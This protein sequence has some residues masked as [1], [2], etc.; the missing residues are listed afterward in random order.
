[1]NR[2]PAKYCN[3]NLLTGIWNRVS[4]GSNVH[5]NLD[6][7][8]L[9]IM[10]DNW[11]SSVIKSSIIFKDPEMDRP[12][13][14]FGLK[15][16]PQNDVRYQLLYCS[17]YTRF[18]VSI[19]TSTE[20]VWTIQKRGLNI[21]VFCNGKTVLNVTASSSVCDNPGYST[22]W[23]SLYWGRKV[24][25]F[26]FPAYTNTASKYYHIGMIILVMFLYINNSAYY[27]EIL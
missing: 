2:G 8:N 25:K 1:L 18:P 17:N 14:G 13:G 15:F 10:T 12:S 16:L 7:S 20:K 23:R 6:A 19:P 4:K 21:V 22:T 5:A 3:N 24:Q 27:A 26:I 9:H 11:K